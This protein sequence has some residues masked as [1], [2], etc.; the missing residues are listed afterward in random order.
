M[1]KDF[2]REVVII[3]V[4]KQAE[5]IA[6]LLNSNKHVNEFFIAKKLGITINQTR[7]ILYKVSDFGLVSSIRKKDKKKGWFTYFWKIEI[8]KSLEFFKD[9]VIKK[10]DQIN[11]QIKSRETKQFYFCE[12][13]NVEYSEESALL[14]D[15][16]C[17]E[18]GNV[19]VL[20]DNAST[21]KELKKSLIKLKKDLDAVEEEIKIEN[22]KV[23]KQR[24]K[25][26]KKRKDEVDAKR[27]DDRKKRKALKELNNP[28]AV[29]KKTTSAKKTSKK[30]PSKKIVK[31]KIPKK[32]KIIKK[33]KKK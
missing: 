24:A 15:F 8:L 20:R 12:F 5:E 14:N 25:D 2:L 26:F 29:I 18:C 16:S 4:G 23:G 33:S 17:P 21:I 22:E 1:L 28:K 9:H 6:D 32:P 30:K 19:F 3:T 7:N 31:K 11:S 10:I 13:C 27:A